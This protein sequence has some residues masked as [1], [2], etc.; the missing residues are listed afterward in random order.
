MQAF[1]DLRRDSSNQEILKS[2]LL[3]I[4][5]LAYEALSDIYYYLPPLFGIAFVMFINLVKKN[6]LFHVIP[7]FVFLL[8]FEASKGYLFLSSIMFFLFSYWIVIPRIENFLN[9]KKCLIPIF[10]F[11][12]YFGFHLFLIL[13]H[14]ILKVDLP[15]FPLILL[16]YIFVETLFLVVLL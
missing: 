14:A 16:Y 4:T 9:C 15:D 6:R 10:V 8:F 11:Y 12:A 2:F 7:I 13:L 5:I 3:L 1:S